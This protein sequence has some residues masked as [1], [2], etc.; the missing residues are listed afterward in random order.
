MQTLKRNLTAI[1]IPY[2]YSV[3][4]KTQMLKSKSWGPEF[5]S[6]LMSSVLSNLAGFVTCY[7][8][9]QQWYMGRNLD[10]SNSIFISRAPVAFASHAVKNLVHANWSCEHCWT[11][12]AIA[13][14]W[15]QKNSIT[16]I[17]MLSFGLA[18]VYSRPEVSSSSRLLW[19]ILQHLTEFLWIIS[20]V[21][22]LLRAKHCLFEST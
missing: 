8:V 18:K 10:G 9:M 12:P 3:N 16:Y 11:S 2:L 6:K 15:L 17:I 19:E 5:K 7:I 4:L 20:P 21:V 1:E 22:S 14:W 13:I